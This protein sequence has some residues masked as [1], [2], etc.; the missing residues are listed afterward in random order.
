VQKNIFKTGYKTAC[1]LGFILEGFF[2]A[3]KKVVKDF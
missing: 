2:Y 1:G 3:L